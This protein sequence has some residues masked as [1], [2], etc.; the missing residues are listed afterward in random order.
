LQGTLKEAGRGTTSSRAGLRQG[1]VIGEVALTFV[2]LTGAGL[3]F[4]SFHRLL[5]VKPGFE[6]DKVLTFHLDLPDSKYPTAEQQALFDKSLL[7]K[8][9]AIPGV[10]SASLASQ[11]PLSE[12]GWDML[13]VI[14]GRPEPPPQLQPS[15]QVHVVSPGYFQTMGIPLLQGR[16]F[17]EQDNREHLRGDGKDWGAG[18]NSIIIDEEFAKQYW[19]NESPIG[20]RIR[21]PWGERSKQPVMTVVGVVGRVK[22]N[23]LSEEGG[24]VQSYLPIYQQPLF[25]MSVVVKTS[26]EPA[27]MMSTIREQVSQLDPT[28]PIYGI[29]TMKEMRDHNVAPDRLNLGLLGGFAVLALVLALIGLYG[30]L[31]FT[32]TQR[33]REIGVR[34]ALGAQ[35]FDVQKL[36][37]GHGMRLI[38]IGAFIGLVGSFALT[39]IL[40]SAL[41][42]VAPTDPLT[43]ASVTLLL[44]AAAIV[45]CYIP[46]RRATK[47]H[48]MV[49]LRQE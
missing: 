11:I 37:V 30:L 47:I 40:A 46:A 20:Q 21:L 31:S 24:M 41:F 23:R 10:K 42:K 29:N 8:M 16:D 49:A 48:P 26:G 1:L 6:V 39:R 12:G 25:G 9:R 5:E 45:S 34:M 7:E 4:L 2:L 22:K 3:L 14:E 36:V 13:F 27:A 35:Q 33:H 32:V 17:T 15:L 18:L 44:C 28:L 19:P 38:F 43:F